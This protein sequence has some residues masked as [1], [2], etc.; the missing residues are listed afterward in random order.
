MV[1]GVVLLGVAANFWRPAIARLRFGPWGRPVHFASPAPLNSRAP[2]Q[3]GPNR[4]V[5]LV[6]G[7]SQAGNF[8]KHRYRD[9][10]LSIGDDSLHWFV[11]ALP[12]VEGEHQSVWPRFAALYRGATGEEVIVA[13]ASVGA[14]TMTQWAPR[15]PGWPLVRDRVARLERLALHP[16]LVILMI[17]EADAEAATAPTAWLNAFDSFL[18]GLRSIGVSVPVMV[19]QETRCFARDVNHELHS[20]QLAASRQPQARRGP[21][22][23]ELGPDLRWDSCHL[24]SEGID[25]LA[26]RLT[27]A[28][29][30]ELPNG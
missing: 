26:R 20:A 27:R 22:L 24:N 25:L 17:G 10:V 12:G 30:L 7:Q 16:D 14:T 29:T 2:D 4:K 28:V 23:D 15:G 1:S 13:V 6:V 19:V 8:A 21:N 9:S 3:I 5:I 18:R 11:G